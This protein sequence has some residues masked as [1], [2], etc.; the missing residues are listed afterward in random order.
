MMKLVYEP[1]DGVPIT[2]DLGLVAQ[3]I[4]AIITAMYAYAVDEN[5]EGREFGEAAVS[6]WPLLQ[7]LMEPIADYFFEPP[8]PRDE[9]KLS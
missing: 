4:Q 2:G 5:G 7:I 3:G 1:K 8:E 9:N 6:V